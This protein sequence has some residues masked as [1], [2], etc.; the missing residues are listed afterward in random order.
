MD[1][2]FYNLGSAIFYAIPVGVALFCINKIRVNRAEIKKLEKKNK[3][4]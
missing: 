2:I 1:N 3:K 4:K